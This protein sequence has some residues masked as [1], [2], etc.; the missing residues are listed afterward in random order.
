MS[1]NIIILN[2][3]KIYVKGET[4][5]LSSMGITDILE[6]K[7]LDFLANLQELDLSG[8]QI[9][10][11]QGLDTLTNLQELYLYEN[12]ITTIQ[13]L[14]TL[15]NLQELSL[16]GNQINEI[17]G[18]E[19]LANLQVLSL[20]WNQITTIQGFD[21]L[22]NL[23]ELLLISNQI[24]EIQELD[25][26]ANLQ[27]LDLS[28]NQINEIKSLKSLAN[29]QGLDLSGNQITTIQGLES[30]TNLQELFL[31]GNQITTIQGLDSLANLQELNLEYNPIMNSREFIKLL[32]FKNIKTI[33]IDYHNLQVV[34]KE[35][36]ESIRE[37]LLNSYEWINEKIVRYWIPWKRKENLDKMIRIANIL[38]NLYPENWKEKNIFHAKLKKLLEER[39]NLEKEDTP[40]YYQMQALKNVFY[41]G[42]GR[43][44]S[45][46]LKYLEHAIKFFKKADKTQCFFF[47]TVY[48]L[49]IKSVLASTK[50]E[51]K[52][53]KEYIERIINLIAEQKDIKLHPSL[54]KLID[55]L[56][57]FQYNFID[58]AKFPERWEQMITECSKKCYTV[59]REECPQLQYSKPG[60]YRILYHIVDDMRYSKGK[61]SSHILE[62]LPRGLIKNE[63]D[64]ELLRLSRRLNKGKEKLVEWLD[65]FRIDEQRY[66]L[67]LLEHIKIVSDEDLEEICQNLYKK[68]L[69][70]Y[71]LRDLIFVGIGGEAKSDKYISY[72]F[73]LFNEIP[74]VQFVNQLDP[75][76]NKIS[77]K[78]IVYID[79]I[80]STGNQLSD[81]WKRFKRQLNNDFFEKNSF[82]F[83]PLFLTLDAKKLI[84]EEIKCDLIF[85][86]ENLLTE[87]NNVLSKEANIFEKAEL[88][89]AKEIFSKYGKK[90]YRKGFLGYGNS[91]LLLVF[92]YNTP[93]NTLPVIW[94]KSDDINFKWTPLFPRRESKKFIRSTPRSFSL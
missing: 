34:N 35:D 23:Q 5:D 93:N 15:T 14:D 24:Q 75:K 16:S 28:G 49:L 6:I 59:L 64:T 91:G 52:N 41:A 37:F 12:Q 67:K 82:I 1:K 47:Y 71:K 69:E 86:K 62:R 19:S 89:I 50:S 36:I 33:G 94:G 90:I 18:L 44:R 65:N 38:I 81:D 92:P 60:V 32:D 30:L 4:L 7:G 72:H 43:D 45:E 9:T 20:S 26:L 80:S 39:I 79:D 3:K 87:K 70:E 61:V 66:A 21:S 74:E 42:T 11:I 2:G 48:S 83:A 40:E 73:R 10:T 53:S 68:I 13:G 54:Q 27:G 58:Y 51:F 76:L 31:S 22:A 63:F 78:V 88:G 77:G 8:N 17:K 25:S 56:P 84:K 46:Q 57:E 55:I 85:L 29:L